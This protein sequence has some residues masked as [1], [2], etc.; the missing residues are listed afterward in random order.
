VNIA[1]NL[2]NP[3]EEDTI[4]PM[5]DEDIVIIGSPLGVFIE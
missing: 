5:I 1:K 2:I 3:I 4:L